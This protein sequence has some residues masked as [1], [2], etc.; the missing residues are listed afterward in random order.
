[1]LAINNKE[2]PRDSADQENLLNGITKQQLITF[3]QIL[4]DEIKETQQRCSTTDLDIEFLID[5]SGSV[6]GRNWQMATHSI[7][8]DWIEATG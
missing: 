5:S 4:L 3:Q 7:A 6:G 1:M 8:T 2:I